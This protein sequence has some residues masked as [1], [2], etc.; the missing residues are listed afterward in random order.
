MRHG[1][2]DKLQTHKLTRADLSINRKQRHASSNQQNEMIRQHLCNSLH[3]T[4]LI[5]C[6]GLPHEK[7]AKQ[8]NGENRRMYMYTAESRYGVK[9]TFHNFRQR[10]Q[11]FYCFYM[12]L[13][14]THTVFLNIIIIIICRVPRV[15][16]RTVSMHTP[17]IASERLK[18]ANS[19]SCGR[20]EILG[21]INESVANFLYD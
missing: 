10:M 11:N 2:T 7:P 1:Y 20:L 14:F 15:W 12:D 3:Q 13:D 21:P 4:Q 18:L 9:T 5:R 6:T 17:V 8:F 16:L 19:P